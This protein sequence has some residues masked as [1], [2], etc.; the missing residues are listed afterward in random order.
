MVKKKKEKKISIGVYGTPSSFVYKK[1]FKKI[2]SWVC[3]AEE[4]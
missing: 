3:L 2:L 4:K 1:I